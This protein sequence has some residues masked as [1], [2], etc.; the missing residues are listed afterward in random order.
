MKL[1]NQVASI[2]PSMRLA[3]LGIRSH[4]SLYFYMSCGGMNYLRPRA[5][6]SVNPCDTLYPALTVA[7]LGEMLP[8][9]TTIHKS[10]LN[11]GWSVALATRC[12]NHCVFERHDE[13]SLSMADAMSSMLI[14]LLENGHVT[15]EQI[16]GEGS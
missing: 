8:A 3:E 10:P 9:G 13:R 5:T 16:N 7:E 4:T 14:W 12:F 11:I 1:E 6:T 2:E 15:A